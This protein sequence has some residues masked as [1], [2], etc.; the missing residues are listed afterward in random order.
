MNTAMIEAVAAALKLAALEAVLPRYRSLGARDVEQKAAGEVV[1]TADREAEL[2]IARELSAIAPDA[3]FV[4]EEACA[5]N[6]GLLDNI[7]KG[8]VWIVDPIDGTGNFAAGR[9]PF[10]LMAALLNEGEIVAS[11]IYDPLGSRMAIAEL[12]GGAWVNG[13]RIHVPSATL[14]LSE[15]RGIVSESFALEAKLGSIMAIEEAVGEVVPSRRCAGDEYPLVATGD[16]HFA[17]YWR[18]LLWDHAPGALLLS[19]AG[20]TV[21]RH[22]GSAYRPAEPGAGMLLAQNGEVAEQITRLLG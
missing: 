8:L 15:L 16:R 10:A 6:P 1:T 21:R 20:G 7:G 11:W 2:I 18:D 14:A 3:R 12:G 13:Q 4:G 22:D 9:P 5:S 19:E 17:V